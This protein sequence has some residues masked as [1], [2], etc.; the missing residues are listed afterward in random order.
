VLQGP[1]KSSDVLKDPQLRALLCSKMS[2]EHVHEAVLVSYWRVRQHMSPIQAQWMSHTLHS[3]QYAL[4]PAAHQ[5]TAAVVETMQ[6][7]SSNT[8]MKSQH[9]ATQKAANPAMSMPCLTSATLAQH[10][11]SATISCTNATTNSSRGTAMSSKQVVAQVVMAPAKLMSD[12]SINLPQP[13]LSAADSCTMQT[14]HSS[15]TSAHQ[16]L[17]QHTE[18]IALAHLS[19]DKLSFPTETVKPI[20]KTS[21]QASLV[22]TIMGLAKSFISWIDFDIEIELSLNSWS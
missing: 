5:P 13:Q 10:Q 20:K 1:V 12:I 15:D 17:P 4:E 21:S 22:S 19:Q 18:P 7:S 6:H 16:Q 11:Q 2:M 9:I 14:I 3:G 8:T